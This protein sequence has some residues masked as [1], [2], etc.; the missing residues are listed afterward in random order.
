MGISRTPIREALRELAAEGFVKMNPNQ[1]IIVNDI[2]IKDLWEVLQIRG[3]LEGLAARLAT[4]LITEEKI[5]ELEACNENMDKLIAKNNI[6]AFGKE[7]N[8]FHEL[9]LDVCGNDRLAQIRKNLADQIYRF[10]NISLRIPGVLE[11]SLKEHREITKALK[12]G[13]ADKADA[14]SKTHIANLLK[15]ISSHEDEKLKVI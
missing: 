9:I 6:L 4:A 14:L 15:N 1:A 2:S 8:K 10:R 3:V 7:S 12:Q 13:D 5:N 11:S